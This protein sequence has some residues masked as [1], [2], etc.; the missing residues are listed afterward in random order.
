MKRPP[1]YNPG[2]LDDREIAELFCVRRRELE[3]LVNTLEKT[4]AI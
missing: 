1:K 4:G 3:I 2:F